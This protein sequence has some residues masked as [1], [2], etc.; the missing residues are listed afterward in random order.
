MKDSIT[1]LAFLSIFHLLGGAAIGFSVRGILRGK[2][3]LV[4]LFMIVWGAMFGCMPFA[5][6]ASLFIALEAP[7]WIAAEAGVLLVA[8]IASALIPDTLLETLKSPAV[9]AIAF[10]GLFMLVGLGVGAVTMMHEPLLALLF[11]GSFT[12]AGA[13]VFF[14]GVKKIFAPPEE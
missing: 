14:T 6:G 7:H 8:L 9:S 12:G 3:S 13:L 4:S 2:P 11:G 1:I 10:G 5:I